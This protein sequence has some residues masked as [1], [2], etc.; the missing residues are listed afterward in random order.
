M[1]KI[2]VATKNKGKI[3]EMMQAFADLPV[4][5]VPLSAFG[6]LPDAVEDGTTFAAN[7]C[8][9]ADFYRRQTKCACLADDSGLE[10]AVLNG[11]PGI[12]SAR[13]AGEQATD[14]ENNAKL[15]QEIKKKGQETS[16]AAYRCVLAFVDEDGTCLTA[17]GSCCGE[18]RPQAK[19]QN[20]FGYD[21]YFYLG[22]RTLAE[23][24]LA[25][26]DAVSHRGEALRRMAKKLALLLE[27]E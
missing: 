1:K 17:E 27:T 22:D 3:K 12:Y 6:E 15:L 8:L 24:T 25:E 16:A 4:E 11:A 13:F 2:V 21:S 10:T 18:I 7:A 20:G 19:G 5:L 23:Y 9:K 26:K 14:E